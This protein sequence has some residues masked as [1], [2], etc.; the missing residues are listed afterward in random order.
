MNRVEKVLNK[1]QELRE[2]VMLLGRDAET[3]KGRV[4]KYNN[5]IT[6][7]RDRES[8]LNKAAVVFKNVA[9]ERNEE[10][11]KTLEDVLNYALANISL[12]QQYEARVE[13]VPSKRSGKEMTLVLTDIETGHERSLKN[14]TG[15]ALSQIISFLMSAIVLKFSGSSRVM[16]LDEVF[17]GLQ[18]EETIRMFG[19]ILVAL[20]KNEGYQFILVEHKSELKN[21]EGITEIALQLKDYDKG[22]EVRET[23]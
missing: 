21:I 6:K 22:L 17:S 11:K 20:A 4:E 14:Q 7:L 12:E 5:D 18:D 8:L 23:V 9:D 15:T 1:V 10:A 19:E 16:L 13:E 3:I 2:E